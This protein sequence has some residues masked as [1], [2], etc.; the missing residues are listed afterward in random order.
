MVQFLTVPEELFAQGQEKLS[1]ITF[2]FAKETHVLIQLV[3][4]LSLDWNQPFRVIGLQIAP[5][6][7]AN[8]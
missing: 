5:L 3:L 4:T 2:L 7:S 1:I 6:W 8:S